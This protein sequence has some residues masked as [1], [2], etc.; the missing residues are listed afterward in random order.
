MFVFMLKQASILLV[1]LPRATIPL[2]TPIAPCQ[3]RACVAQAEARHA[4]G[5][6]GTSVGR[7]HS[8]ALLA[9]LPVPRPRDRPIHRPDLQYV[10]ADAADA[11][12]SQLQHTAAL[13][14]VLMA[15]V[16]QYFTVR[17]TRLQPSVWIDF[18]FAHCHAHSPAWGGNTSRVCV[19]IR[20]SVAWR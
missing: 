10:S 3:V 1:H 20:N 16:M 8:S 11:V 6:V 15:L 18:L 2:L 7:W 13:P 17:Q 5:R 19:K 14:A 12:R 4:I 9:T